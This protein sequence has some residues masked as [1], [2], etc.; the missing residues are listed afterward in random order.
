M[1]KTALTVMCAL[2]LCA[3]LLVGICAAGS[4]EPLV[5]IPNENGEEIGI[6]PVD[7]VFYLPS[8]VDIQR[9]G[10]DP[11]PAM[12]YSGNQISGTL[13]SGEALDLTPFETV[14]ERGEKCYRLKLS[15]GGWMK[16]YTFYHD[17]TLST[18][19]VSTSLGLSQIDKSKS[20]R[21]KG[22]RITI[23]DSDGAAEYC[24][25]AADT[26]SEI[27]GRGNATFTYLKKP[28]QIKLS[29]KTDLFGMGASKTWILLANYT[30]QSALHNALAFELSEALD[31][32]YS[33]EYRYVNLYIDGEYRGLY[34][35]CEKVQVDDERVDITDLEKANE[36]ANPNQALDSFAVK[37]ITSSALIDDSIL[38]YYTPL[39]LTMKFWQA[40]N[41]C[42]AIVLTDC[43]HLAILMTRK[44]QICTKLTM[45]SAMTD[46]LSTATITLKT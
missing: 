44:L 46:A 28:Y 2:A 27:K 38:R 3:L 26:K 12:S 31:V 5:L 45:L 9:V 22:A 6:A 14:D 30:D 29:A 35:I 32:P 4:T 36:Q 20:T 8:S 21:D 39:K 23:L 7:G 40:Q 41:N 34:M 24:D 18:V 13:G 17:D 37:K 1:K 33:I 25:L 15:A 43:K 42:I 10:F 11:D 16:E 19:F